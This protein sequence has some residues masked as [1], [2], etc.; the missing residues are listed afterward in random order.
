MAEIPD[1]YLQPPSQPGTL[2]RLTYQTGNPF[3]CAAYKPI[4]KEAWVYLPYGYNAERPYNVFYLSHG[5]WSDETTIMGTDENPTTLKH[6]IACIEEGRMQPM[7][8]VML[9]YNNTSDRDSWDY[10]LALDL[11]DQFHQELVNDLSGC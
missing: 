7:I 5:G 10:G 6:V 1:D 4:N 2:D 8:L 9:T 11:T 3:L